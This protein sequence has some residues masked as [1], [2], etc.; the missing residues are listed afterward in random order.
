MVF[1][2]FLRIHVENEK[3]K[4]KKT[5]LEAVSD[6]D[7]MDAIEDGEGRVGVMNRNTRRKGKD[8]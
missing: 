8:R 5:G 7:D 3:I 1:V 2:A 6:G 4:I